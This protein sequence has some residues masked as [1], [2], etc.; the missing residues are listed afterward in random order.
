M[1]ILPALAYTIALGCTAMVTLGAI[2]RMIWP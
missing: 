2:I 1:R